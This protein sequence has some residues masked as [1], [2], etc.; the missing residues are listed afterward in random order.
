MNLKK[1]LKNKKAQ[2]IVEYIIIFVVL[3][4]GVVTVFGGFSPEKINIKTAFDQAIN[5]AINKINE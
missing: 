1:N 5:Q 4:I 2:T 3:A